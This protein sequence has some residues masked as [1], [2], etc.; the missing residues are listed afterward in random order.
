[1]IDSI[2]KGKFGKE[3]EALPPILDLRASNLAGD[4]SVA[5]Q[6]GIKTKLNITSGGAAS[7]LSK[8]FVY[9]GGAQTFTADFD[10]VQVDSIL[11]ENTPLLRTQYDPPVGKN[12]TILDPLTV[13]AVIEL[14]YWKANAVNATNYTKAEVNAIV[15]DIN[16]I[17][18]DINETVI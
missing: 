1:M 10:I 8:P 4:L 3:V 17:L 12:F 2:Y 15:G 9:T 7:L 13:G 11:V 5:E 18:D 14:N 6:D 16:T